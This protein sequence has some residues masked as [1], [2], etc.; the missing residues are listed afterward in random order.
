MGGNRPSEPCRTQARRVHGL[1]INGTYWRLRKGAVIPRQAKR[2][3]E[4]LYCNPDYA[5]KDEQ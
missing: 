5:V 1:N 4:P 2:A 3:E